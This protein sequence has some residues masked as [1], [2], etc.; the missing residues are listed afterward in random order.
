MS[1]FGGFRHPAPEPRTLLGFLVRCVLAATAAELTELQTLSRCFLVLGRYV[2]AAF[3][4]GA[5][6][7]NIVT[8]HNTNP[9][10]EAR[11]RRAA[12]LLARQR[13]AYPPIPQ[14]QRRCRR[15][16]FF[17]LHEWRSAGLSPWRSGQSTRCPSECCPRAS[18]SPRP[19]A[20]VRRQ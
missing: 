13:R 18:P 2:I 7:H 9:S 10:S 12:S 3:A 14:L 17:R 19:P 8:R 1:G 16:R 4:I 20:D 15:R 11:L 5:L 6:Q